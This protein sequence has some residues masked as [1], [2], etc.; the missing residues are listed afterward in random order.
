MK[1]SF[2]LDFSLQKELGNGL[3]SLPVPNEYQPS[4]DALEQLFAI[5]ELRSSFD[6]LQLMISMQNFYGSA[7]R[8]KAL[9]ADIETARSGLAMFLAAINKGGPWLT[10]K[11]IFVPRRNESKSDYFFKEQD[12]AFGLD[13]FIS[14]AKRY[15][16]QLDWLLRNDPPSKG[17][18]KNLSARD[19]PSS[20]KWNR[21]SDYLMESFAHHLHVT[22]RVVD[23]ANDVSQWSFS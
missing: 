11:L 22:R 21:R 4:D 3:R 20:N 23:S 18:G 6:L 7:P 14:R 12:I 9:R 16:D 10:R 5:E 13:K 8:E 1:W 17:R 19:C 15:L 2:E